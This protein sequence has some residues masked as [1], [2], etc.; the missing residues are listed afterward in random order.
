[1]AVYYGDATGFVDPNVAAA[2]GGDGLEAGGAGTVFRKSDTQT[3]GDLVVDNGGFATPSMS[4]PLRGI[5]VGTISALGPQLLED[6]SGSFPVPDP[7]TGTLGL[8]G[9]SLNPNT[10][11]GQLFTVIDNT[12]TEIFTDPTDGDMTLISTPGSPYIGVYTLDNLTVI[13]GASMS[14]ADECLVTGSI[15]VTG[16]SLTCAGLSLP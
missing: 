11:Q 3:Y 14:T 8:V 2:I 13:D 7:A 15:D 1:V 10:A 6:L 9:L 4:T 5:G 16:G 12:A